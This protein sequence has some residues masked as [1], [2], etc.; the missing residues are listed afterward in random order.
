MSKAEFDTLPIFDLQYPKHIDGVDSSIL[1]PVE[2]W[3]NKE[4]YSMTLKKVAEMFNENFKKYEG[5]ATDAVRSG[6]PKL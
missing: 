6:G 2:T 4:E 1:N 5:V 3:K